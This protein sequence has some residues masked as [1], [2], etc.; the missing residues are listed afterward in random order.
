MANKRMFTLKIVDTDAFLDMPHTSQLLYFHLAMRADDDGFVANPKMIMRVTDSKE[1]DFKI[2]SAKKFIIPFD[3]GI[4]VIKH[5]KMHNTIKNDRKIETAYKE[6]LAKL[7]LD[8]NK[9]Y[10][11]D[12]EWNQ[13]GSEVEPQIR[14]DQVRSD[15]IRSDQSRLD[16]VSM[17]PAQEAQDF[18]SGGESAKNIMDKFVGRGIEE[19]TLTAEVQKFILY[20]TELNKTG[21]KQRWEME[22]TFEVNRR[23]ATWLSR[24]QKFSS[25]GI[26]KKSKTI[27]I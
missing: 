14:L 6:E 1:D 20:W 15:K 3:S 2:L 5:W 16:E 7:S 21:K 27:T 10:T 13:N 18:F 23:L 4:C 9:S 19:A 12:P 24:S 25:G 11:M 26:D 8:E 17:T 22:K